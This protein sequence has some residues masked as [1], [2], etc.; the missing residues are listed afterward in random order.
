[1]KKEIKNFKEIVKEEAPRILYLGIGI[2]GGYFFGSK[3]TKL[4]MGAGLLTVL[5]SNPELKK[6]YLETLKKFNEK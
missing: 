3:L 6:M 4:G 1:M 5:D 2:A